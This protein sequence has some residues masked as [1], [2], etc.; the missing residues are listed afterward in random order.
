MTPLAV[1]AKET[2]KYVDF[3]I[4][5]TLRRWARRKHAKKSRRWIRKKYFSL[6]TRTGIF[7]TKAKIKNGFVRIFQI[8]RAEI[9]PIVRY[10]KVRQKTNPFDQEHSAFSRVE[11]D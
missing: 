9:T 1:V 5:V 3:H 8:F 11:W 6:G 7:A 2:F 10:I 4:F